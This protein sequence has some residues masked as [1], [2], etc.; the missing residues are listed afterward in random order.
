MNKLELATAMAEKTGL[1]KK[2]AGEAIDAITDII[3]D[4]LRAKESVTLMGFG[5]FEAVQSAERTGRN[6]HTGE[7]VKVPAKY[8]VRFK[9]SQMLKEAVN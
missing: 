8:K 2:L 3:T 5:T 1:T 6:P 7:S 4:T 9:P